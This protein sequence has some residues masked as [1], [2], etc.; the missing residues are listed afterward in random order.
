MQIACATDRRF[1]KHLA[2]MI[3][4]L[5]HS[6]P[7]HLTIHLIY[8]EDVSAKSVRLLS[9]WIERSGHSAKMIPFGEEDVGNLLSTARFPP[10]AWARILLPRLLP[11]VDRVLYLD[12]DVLALDDVEPLWRI[13]LEGNLL[14]AVVDPLHY[15]PR[16]TYPDDIGV[17]ERTYFNSGVLLMDLAGI[18]AQGL[19]SD[20]LEVAREGQDWLKYPDQEVLNFVLQGKCLLTHPKWNALSALLV[21]GRGV[22]VY[23][24]DERQEAIQK[25]TLVH[26]EGPLHSKPWH[27]QCKNP[28][29]DKYKAYRKMTPWPVF[30]PSGILRLG[31]ARNM[32]LGRRLP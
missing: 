28:F 20:L 31:V 26:F 32:I 13:D 29:R 24:E 17:S 15:R 2:T 4:S 5:M 18:R 30:W 8:A 23:D 21:H 14:A 25:P 1:L 6:V 12:A 3:A 11:E 9:D 16:S 22:G 19:D 10:I 27:V 7:H